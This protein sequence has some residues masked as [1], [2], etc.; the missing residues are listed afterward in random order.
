[1]RQLTLSSMAN[2]LI[3][4]VGNLFDSTDVDAIAHGVN[5]V[6]FLNTNY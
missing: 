4:R 5:C 3:H 2:A 6:G 1:M